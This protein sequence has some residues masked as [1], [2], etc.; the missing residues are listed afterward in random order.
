MSTLDAAPKL[1]T[2]SSQCVARHLPRVGSS[3]ARRR[4]S[5]A[6]RMHRLLTWRM[7]LVN[8]H[9]TGQHQQIDASWSRTAVGACV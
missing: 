2:D 6:A 9:A 3:A 1:A 5:T 4:K 7:L 8:Q